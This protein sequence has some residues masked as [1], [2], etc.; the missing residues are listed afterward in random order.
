MESKAGFFSWLIF[1]SRISI[2]DQ[3]AIIGAVVVQLRIEAP[4]YIPLLQFIYD[5]V[6]EFVDPWL[7][8]TIGNG[9]WPKPN[10]SFA[11]CIQRI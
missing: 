1:L 11:F 8:P 4:H 3:T 7:Q 5:L 2:N 10:K 9:Q 6:I